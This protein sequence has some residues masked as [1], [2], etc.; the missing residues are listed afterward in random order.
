MH[1]EPEY[2]DYDDDEYNYYPEK[3]KKNEPEIPFSF[4][5]NTWEIWL[6]DVIQDIVTEENKDGVSWTFTFPEYSSSK[7]INTN[8]I[9]NSDIEKKFIYL[10]Q[11]CFD[12]SVW[13]YKYF[14]KDYINI[15]YQQHLISHAKHI[16]S[17]PAYYRSLYEIMN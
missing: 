10:G 11:N 5:W 8:E 6:A 9:S 1:Q 17:Q 16:L 2:D 15:E 7:E 14:A 12:E 3:H 13:K 4:D